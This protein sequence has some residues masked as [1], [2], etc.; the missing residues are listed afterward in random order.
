MQDYCLSFSNINRNNLPDVFCKKGFLRNLAKFTGKHMCTSLFFNKKGIFIKKI[1]IFI[2]KETVVQFLFCE[3]CEISKTTFFFWALPVVASV[4]SYFLSMLP[5]HTLH[6]KYQ[7]M[8]KCRGSHQ[9][10][11]IKR[12]LSKTSQNSQESTC[13]RVSFFSKVAGLQLY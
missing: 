5:F 9:R 1:C 10:R 11:S 6:W 7:K 4:L 13:A 3:F 12:C 8:I 2:K